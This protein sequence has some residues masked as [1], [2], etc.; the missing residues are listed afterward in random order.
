MNFDSV[1][2]HVHVEPD[3]S[4]RLQ[5]GANCCTE[6]DEIVVSGGVI[7]PLD[8]SEVTLTPHSELII[9]HPITGVERRI[10]INPPQETPVGLI[11]RDDYYV[12]SWEYE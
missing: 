9:R 1:R 6:I 5:A 11:P 4:V 3:S 2:L 12:I 7:L 10:R 8:G